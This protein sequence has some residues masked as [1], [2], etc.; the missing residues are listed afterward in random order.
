MLLTGALTLHHI[1]MQPVRLGVLLSNIY[2][3]PS[4]CSELAC[5]YEFPGENGK[6]TQNATN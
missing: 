5:V 2:V 6:Q 3:P 1:D 4:E